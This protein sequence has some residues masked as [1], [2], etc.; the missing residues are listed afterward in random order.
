MAETANANLDSTIKVMQK[1]ETRLNI[2]ENT[3]ANLNESIKLVWD[4]VV[5]LSRRMRS[6]ELVQEVSL[7]MRQFYE[8]QRRIVTGLA[9]LSHHRLPPELVNMKALTSTLTS[10]RNDIE[11]KNMRL[12]INNFHDVFNLDVSYAA[13]PNGSIWYE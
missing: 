4:K 8:E 10:L 7:I 6:D 9:A 11:R 5:T 2:D 13:Y 3:L 1:Q 12:G